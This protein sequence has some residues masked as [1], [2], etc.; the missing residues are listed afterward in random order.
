MDWALGLS[1]EIRWDQSIYDETD[2]PKNCVKF[3]L[4]LKFFV[5]IEYTY[6]EAWGQK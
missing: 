3:N 6:V 2:V 1:Y 5:N 4:S